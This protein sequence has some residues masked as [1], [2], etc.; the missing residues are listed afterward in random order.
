[1][2]VLDRGAAE[3]P[4]LAGAQR[5][6]RI[7]AS[8]H[9]STVTAVAFSQDH[10]WAAT[11]GEDKTIRIWGIANGREDLSPDG[12]RLA[13][14]SADGAV[15]VWDPTTAASIYTFNLGIGWAQQAAFSADGR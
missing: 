9:T 7:F 14:T 12:H 11:G 15:R 3:Q 2:I 13:S 4:D 1:M 8:G 6:D 5:P 10:R